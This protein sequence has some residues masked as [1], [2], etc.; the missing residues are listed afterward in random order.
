MSI[1]KL[2]VDRSFVQD[3]APDNS[4]AALLKGIIGL[5]HSLQLE[6]VADGIDTQQPMDFLQ[7]FQSD[8]LRGYFFSKPL[9]A[10]ECSAWIKR[11]NSA[12]SG[13]KVQHK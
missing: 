5:A 6:V 7:Q 12:T 13:L 3:I 4:D 1:D 11:Q 8:E 9:P 10:D 2:K